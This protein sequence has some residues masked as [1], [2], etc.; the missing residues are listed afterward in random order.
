MGYIKSKKRIRTDDYIGIAGDWVD[1][2][3][4]DS[5]SNVMIN[6]EYV[7]FITY[8]TTFFTESNNIINFLDRKLNNEINNEFLNKYENY[9]KYPNLYSDILLRPEYYLNH[10]T[11][12][13]YQNHQENTYQIQTLLILMLS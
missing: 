7:K 8:N 11:D 9:A 10:K 6:Y 5:S 1:N 2:K 13:N 12:N 3:Y 4:Y